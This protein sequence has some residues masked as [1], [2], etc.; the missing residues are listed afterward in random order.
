MLS[1]IKTPGSKTSRFNH[2]LRLEYS[3]TAT[4]PLNIAHSDPGHNLYAPASRLAM[5]EFPQPVQLDD[6]QIAAARQAVETSHWIGS[7]DSL[8]E[9]GTDW[10]RRK[11]LGLDTEFVR[12]RT[13]FPKPG[14]V[15]LSDGERIWLLDPVGRREFPSLKSILLQPDI[16]KILHS[17]GEDLEIF[18]ILADALPRPL[19]DTQIAAAMLGNPL[20]CRYEH[21]VEQCFGV[22]LAGGEARSDWCRRPLA[23]RLLEYAAQDVIWLPR[24]HER[25]SEALDQ[26]GRLDWLEED[27][28][29][30]VDRAEARHSSQPV[31]RVKGAGRLSDPQLGWLDRLAQWRE[32]EAQQRDLPR[33]FVVRDE[34]LLDLAARADQAGALERSIATLPQPVRRR[35]GSVLRQ[36]LESGPNEAY[37]RPAELVSLTP[38]QRQA[39]KQAQQ[40]VRE[41][42]ESL[43]VEPA[44][45]ASKRELMRLVRGERPDWLEGWRGDV[46]G[47]LAG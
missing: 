14:L 21:L 16:T 29:R 19:F 7:E 3:F 1:F 31:L 25:L 9:S 8:A 27:C 47:D 2:Y 11:T 36:L 26:A 10:N 12:E 40:V 32:D 33:G 5:T 18:R 38:D 17:V 46:I 44:L 13:Y 24:L 45:I 42:A 6:R 20:Q 37:Q 39:V 4:G 23:P 34:A 28:A 41:Q 15:Q 43:N 30:L 35:Y 22:E